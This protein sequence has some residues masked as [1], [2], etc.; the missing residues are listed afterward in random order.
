MKLTSYIVSALVTGVLVTGCK[1]T[2]SK[3]T[4]SASNETP[5]KEVA[6][7][8]PETASFKID[9]MVCPDGCAKMIEKKLNGLN[10]VQE[11]KVDFETKTV[12]VNFDLDQISSEDL[13]KTVETSG[14]GKTYKVSDVKTG[15]KG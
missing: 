10:G 14:D 1:D 5:K 13:V 12:T 9:G 3:P 2:A 11:A 4:M 7:A 6:A 15:H 8:H